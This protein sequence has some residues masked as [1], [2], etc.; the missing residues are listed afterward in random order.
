M[1]DS[2]E[3]AVKWIEMAIERNEAGAKQ[4]TAYALRHAKEH[5]LDAAAELR[6]LDRDRERQAVKIEG[7]VR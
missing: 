3:Q 2:M 7:T 6:L 1:S 5:A 4:A